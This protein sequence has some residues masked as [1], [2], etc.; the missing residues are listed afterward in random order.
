MKPAEF[1]RVWNSI[2]PLL[3]K[4]PP[5]PKGG[6]PRCNDKDV[7][8]GIL[9]ILETGFSLGKAPQGDG[10]RLWHDL[11]AAS[12]TMAS[13]RGMEQAPCCASFG[14]Q[15][16]KKV[17][18]G[19]ILRRCR[20]S[21]VPPGG[22]ETG[23]NPTDRGK[24]GAKRHLVVNMDGIPLVCLLSGATRHDSKMV[25]PTLD[26]LP[27]IGGTRGRLRKRPRK[28]HAD[29][30][31][32]NTACRQYCR[33]RGM[34]PRIAR[35]GVESS[36]RLGRHRWVV[37]R[38]VSWLNRFRKLRIRYERSAEAYLALCTLACSVITLRF[39]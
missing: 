36:E 26:A 9:F 33:N 11:L 18:M 5:K 8:R 12:A 10:M 39:C 3:P 25:A 14:A 27:A 30:G 2:E 35:R 19:T 13:C 15:P 23:P 22:H 24:S 16:R 4:E 6:R 38:T 20:L 28:V 32:D 21:A 37:E 29:K 31:Y 1:E 34:A 7:L 17:Q